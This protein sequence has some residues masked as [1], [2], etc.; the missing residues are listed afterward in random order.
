[1]ETQSHSESKHSPLGNEEE[2]IAELKANPQ[3][4]F[5]RAK[6]GSLRHLFLICYETALIP[7]TLL[8]HALDAVL[9][10]SHKGSSQHPQIPIAIVTVIG[11]LQEILFPVSLMFEAAE[12]GEDSND[13]ERPILR[14][15]NGLMLC[16]KE[17]FE[18]YTH[19]DKLLLQDERLRISTYAAFGAFFAAIGGNKRLGPMLYSDTENIR[20]SIRIWLLSMADTGPGEY[21]ILVQEGF[22]TCLANE[23]IQEKAVEILVQESRGNVDRI[24]FACIS[25]MRANARRDGYPWLLI[26][27]AR[28]CSFLLRPDGPKALQDAFYRLSGISALTKSIKHFYTSIPGSNSLIDLFIRYMVNLLDALS[29]YRALE[30]FTEAITNG[31]FD[32]IAECAEKMAGGKAGD[33]ALESCEPVVKALNGFLVFESVVSASVRKLSEMPQEKLQGI[34]ESRLGPTWNSFRTLLLERAIFKTEIDRSI[35]VSGRN[36]PC[37]NCGEIELASVLKLCGGCKQ[38]MYCS[39]K[40][41]RQHWKEHNHKDVCSCRERNSRPLKLPDIYFL[42]HLIMFDLRRHADGV[43]KVR[44]HGS[45][46]GD[47]SI[48]A[49]VGISDKRTGPKYY[50]DEG[51]FVKQVNPFAKDISSL[52]LSIMFSRGGMADVLFVRTPSPSYAEYPRLKANVEAGVFRLRS[53]GHSFISPIKF[54]NDPLDG[55][56]DHKDVKLEGIPDEVDAILRYILEHNGLSDTPESVASFRY[57]WDDLRQ[58]SLACRED[59][60]WPFESIGPFPVTKPLQILDNAASALADLSI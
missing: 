42:T 37:Y 52:P 30:L 48:I 55:S 45:Y 26:F 16:L 35:E 28:V 53:R 51:Q 9:P 46:F 12:D 8:H 27:Q 1:M 20:K 50:V 31:L 47:I 17:A 58:I 11:Q 13:V 7:R 25:E 2:L 15:W 41:Q 6:R 19:P 34:Q 5:F 56:Q 44:L 32:I 43:K 4:C 21:R 54:Q 33:L 57:S 3:L 23:K 24:A 22:F 29:D 18:V 36:M 38:A 10:F 60:S 40:C 59:E 14:H 49:K 39:S